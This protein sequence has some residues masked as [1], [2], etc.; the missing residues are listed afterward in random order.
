MSNL[1]IRYL[2]VLGCVHAK[3][4]VRLSEIVENNPGAVVGAGGEHDTGRAV[5]LT[6][7]PGAVEGVGDEEEGHH[8]HK[9]HGDALLLRIGGRILRGKTADIVLQNDFY[10]IPVFFLIKKQH[11][12]F[13]LSND[14]VPIYLYCSP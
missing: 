9:E 6:R 14:T 11:V 4:P 5:G 13:F 10:F 12:V 1:L 8:A 7:H 3:P 2:G